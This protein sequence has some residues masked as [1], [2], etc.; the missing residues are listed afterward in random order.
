MDLAGFLSLL[1]SESLFFR[2]ADKFEDHL[3]GT[4]PSSN[5][6]LRE[7]NDPEKIHYYERAAEL[8]KSEIQYF[9]GQSP[10]VERNSILER[11]RDELERLIVLSN[12]PEAR[13]TYTEEVILNRNKAREEA[14]RSID[15]NLPYE[16]TDPEFIHQEMRRHT[17]ISCWY[18]GENES[19]VMWR[20]YTN[21]KSGIAIRTSYARLRNQLEKNQKMFIIGK[22]EYRDYKVEALSD[23]DTYIRFF[24]KDRI[25][26]RESEFRLIHRHGTV[27][28]GGRYS[29]E[30]D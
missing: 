3:E 29:C 25:F 27:Q 14:Q 5:A 23:F 11:K 12:D 17:F 30:A 16:L 19:S 6:R 13:R 10:S 28:K 18:M 20:G 8:T 4:T 2:R 24:S 26:A 9:E 7:E 21:V 1:S 15:Q 22:V